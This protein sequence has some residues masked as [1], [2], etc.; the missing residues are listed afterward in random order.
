MLR[1]L[2]LLL[3]FVPLA[4][5][6]YYYNDTN[7][8]EIGDGVPTLIP[9]IVPGTPGGI[10]TGGYNPVLPNP[11]NPPPGEG[12][13]GAPPAEGPSPVEDPYADGYVG[14]VQAE[15]PPDPWS[16]PVDTDE[17]VFN[18]LLDSGALSGE[19]L[20]EI[21]EETEQGS[22][23]RSVFSNEAITSLWGVT[24]EGS[25]VREILSGKYE[26]RE[27]LSLW[28]SKKTGN[29]NSRGL[30][31]VGAS[32]AIADNNID[33]IR[34]RAD[35][36]QITYRSRGYLFAIFP[37]SFPVRVTVVPEASDGRVKVKL[38]WYRFFVREFF[39]AKSLTAE[40]DAV[41]VAEIKRSGGGENDIRTVLL[42]AVA[43]FLK[44]KVGTI[45]DS[46]Y[47]GT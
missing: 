35:A 42:D 9:E 26:L 36:F 28:R 33:T 8:I 40:I 46:I 6:A 17:E 37:K 39:T 21:G 18:L 44:K 20:T 2:V 10:V 19:S 15:S 38:P 23:F 45:T 27:I 34:F 32:K 47:L 3:L 31:L 13:I 24:V 16:G 5:H 1:L 4:S 14:S 41:V 43:G 11:N 30:G 22:F 29:L 7:L 12:E 25:R